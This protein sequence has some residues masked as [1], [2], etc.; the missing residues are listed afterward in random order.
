MSVFP[1]LQRVH[2]AA[3]LQRAEPLLPRPGRDEYFLAMAYLASTR[4]TCA[5]AARGCVLVSKDGHVL[6]TGYNGVPPGRPHCSEERSARCAGA[7]APSGSALD[8][9]MA[10]HAEMNALV[11]CRDKR[12]IFAC[13]STASPCLTCAKLLLATPCEIL[14]FGEKYP[15]WAL[16]HDLWKRS[17]DCYNV[18]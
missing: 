10:T 2:V 14:V 1:L 16:V 4:A 12:E 5:R 17:Y 7:D 13:Y 8:Q 9:C 6:A 18:K 3:L 15:D 11:Q